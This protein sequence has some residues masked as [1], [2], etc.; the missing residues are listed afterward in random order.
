MSPSPEE[1]PAT[2][3]DLIEVAAASIR[4]FSGP[5]PPPEV[6]AAYNQILPGAAERILKMAEEQERHR[7]QIE[8]RVVRS[9]TFAQTAGVIFGF[10]LALIAIAGGIWL[11]YFGKSGAGLTTIIAA[12]AGLVA[13]FIYGKHEQ[14]RELSRKS[15]PLEEAAE[16]SRSKPFE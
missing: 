9:N 13:T 16:K 2:R 11:A 14:R 1:R 5:L 6:L 8:A 7:H 12:V 3:A 10:I 4:H 15:A